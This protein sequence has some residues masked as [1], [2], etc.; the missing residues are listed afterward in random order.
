MVCLYMQ[1]IKTEIKEKKRKEKALHT[2]IILTET[3]NKI[4]PASSI[5]KKH[6][7]V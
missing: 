7:T 6:K 4:V 3:N 1:L 5:K 2:V